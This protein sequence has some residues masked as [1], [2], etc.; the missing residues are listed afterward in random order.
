MILWHSKR[1]LCQHQGATYDITS[2]P[3]SIT[4]MP[5][6][7]S[8]KES[9]TQ[10]TAVRANKAEHSFASTQICPYV[11][12]PLGNAGKTSLKP[13]SGKGKSRMLTRPLH[14]SDLQRLPSPWRENMSAP[15]RKS[16]TPWTKAV[17]GWGEMTSASA[18]SIK[19]RS[20]IDTAWNLMV[21]VPFPD[22]PI[23]ENASL[24]NLAAWYSDHDRVTVYVRCSQGGGCCAKH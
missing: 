22:L 10:S 9:D 12:R 21:E 20:N 4:A 17:L 5:A 19:N 18:L 11:L 2:A 23:V 3:M 1:R 13:C 8:V 14:E 16:L 24:W 7:S 15:G 6:A